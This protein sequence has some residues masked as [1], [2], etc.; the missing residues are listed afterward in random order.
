MLFQPDGAPSDF[1]RT[2]QIIEFAKDRKSIDMKTARISGFMLVTVDHAKRQYLV[3]FALGSSPAEA[4]ANAMARNDQE[5]G[6]THYAHMAFDEVSGSNST[7]LP[8]GG[9]EFAR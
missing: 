1:F 7:A 6:R 5:S 8:H 4:K 3:R 9:D 2:E